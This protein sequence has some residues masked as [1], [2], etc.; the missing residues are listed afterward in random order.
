MSL[1]LTFMQQRYCM[2]FACFMFILVLDQSSH[3]WFSFVQILPQKIKTEFLQYETLYTWQ[4]KFFLNYYYFFIF[5]L[6]HNKQTFLEKIFACSSS[7]HTLNIHLYFSIKESLMTLW[8]V[9]IS[10]ISQVALAFNKNNSRA[11][12]IPE[13]C[14]VPDGIRCLQHCKPSIWQQ[15]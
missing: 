2:Y 15:S 12:F 5:V 10:L 1:L 4:C 3:I 11:Y 9:Y 8:Q 14:N 13:K 7:V 6:F